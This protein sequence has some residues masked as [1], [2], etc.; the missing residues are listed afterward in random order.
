MISIFALETR[1]FKIKLSRP[2]H[3]SYRPIYK[4]VE[5][6]NFRSNS[7]DNRGTLKVQKYY[8]NME[9]KIN[10]FTTCI[11]LILTT[12]WLGDFY[13]RLFSNSFVLVEFP[14]CLLNTCRRCSISKF[15]CYKELY[16]TILSTS[17][18]KNADVL[19][20]SKV[21]NVLT[22]GSGCGSL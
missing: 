12:L 9:Q 17:D 4:F 3:I 6:Q 5:F 15:L 21:R 14:S 11:N 19:L 2:I 16:Y 8:L 13:N 18:S 7:N 20:L 22:F 10:V 1:V